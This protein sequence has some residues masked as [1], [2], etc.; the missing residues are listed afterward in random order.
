M[1]DIDSHYTSTKA[2]LFMIIAAAMMNL[3]QVFTRIFHRDNLAETHAC[4][5]RPTDPL[6]V[7]VTLSFYKY[8][9]IF[10]ICVLTFLIKKKTILDQTIKIKSLAGWLTAFGIGD[11]LASM[12][13]FLGS[14]SVPLAFNSLLGDLHILVAPLLIYFLNPNRVI[15]QKIFISIVGFSG[16]ILF[17]Y[18]QYDQNLGSNWSILL[19][20][21]A[22]GLWCMVALASQKVSLISHNFSQIAVAVSG[23]ILTFSYSTLFKLPL[24]T[25]N[26]VSGTLSAAIGLSI[27]AQLFFV[28]SMTSGDVIASLIAAPAYA[29][30]GAIFGWLFFGETLSLLEGIA[31]VLVLTAIIA[32]GLVDRFQPNSKPPS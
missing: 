9:I 22:S 13:L 14:L 24:L 28:K 10:L 16:T 25:Y 11:A 8:L 19:P 4:F 21:S 5:S 15:R 18:G 2:M 7:V 23:L 31:A 17:A 32:S 30:F 12:M 3:S 20:L 6:S 27:V 26:F 1:K 29:C